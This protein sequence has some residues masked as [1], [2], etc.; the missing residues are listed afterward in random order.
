MLPTALEETP[1]YKDPI[2][3]LDLTVGQQTTDGIV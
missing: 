1:Q 2:F 3:A